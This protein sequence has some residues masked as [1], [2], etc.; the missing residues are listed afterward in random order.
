M[1]RKEFVFFLVSLGQIVL[2]GG[3]ETKKDVKKQRQN[4]LR[5]KQQ[6]NVS[7]SKKRIDGEKARRY[8][9]QRNLKRKLK[10]VGHKTMARV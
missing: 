5:K 8:T 3:T 10:R 2:Q 9:S 4:Y 6:I 7:D 1:G